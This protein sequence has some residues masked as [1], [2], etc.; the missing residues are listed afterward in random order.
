MIKSKRN[1]E[2][3]F[4]GDNC[5][6]WVFHKSENLVVKQEMMPPKTSEKL[7]FHELT[8]QFFYILKGEAS[9]YIEEEKFTIKSGEGIA[10]EP[11]KKHYI[12]NETKQN[13]EFL[14]ISNPSTDEDRVLLE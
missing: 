9:F 3:Y 10:I 2:H 7:H 1:T 6:S 8:Q 5:D 4:W 12:A 14:V 13:L 11:K